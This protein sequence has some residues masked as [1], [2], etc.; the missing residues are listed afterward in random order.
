[1]RLL[2][3]VAAVMEAGSGL[4]LLLIPTPTI[5]TLLG[6]P[7]GTPSGLVAAR[8]AGAALLAL[9]IASWQVRKGESGNPRLGV[10]HASLVYFFAATAVFVHAGIRMQLQSEFLWPAIVIHLAL[11]SWCLVLVW[12]SRRKASTA[13]NGLPKEGSNLPAE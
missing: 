6:V 1:M 13:E 7:L 8:I 2:L 11:G 10:V 9:G 5:T 12:L 4:L 3:I